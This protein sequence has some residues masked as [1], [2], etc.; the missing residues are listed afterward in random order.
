LFCG[1]PG[2]GKTVTAEA[3]AGELGLPLIYARFDSVISS[4]LGRTSANLRSIFDFAL[5]GSYVI[6]FD[7]F[8]AVGKSRNDMGDHGELKRVV[9]SFLQL[10]DSFESDNILIAATNHESLLDSALWRRFDEVLFFDLPTKEQIAELIRMK[11]AGF[12]HTP[13]G[14]NQEVIDLMVGFSHADVERTCLEAIKHAIL[15]NRRQVNEK[16]FAASLE[17][18]LKRKEIVQR[19]S[20]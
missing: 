9:N 20:A 15:S 16:D 3:I 14:K 8:D 5:Q 4:Y 1:P 12:P 7:E 2:C 18:Q 19:T 11:L 17:H 13:I 6:L 10:L